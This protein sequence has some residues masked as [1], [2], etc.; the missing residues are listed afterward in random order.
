[1]FLR[2]ILRETIFFFFNKGIVHSVSKNCFIVTR[3]LFCSLHSIIFVVR[4]QAFGPIIN[5]FRLNQ[6]VFIPKSF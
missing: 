2:G 1:M 3:Y 6:K 4:N 5:F